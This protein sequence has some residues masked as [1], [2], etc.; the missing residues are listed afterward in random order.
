[1]DAKEYLKYNKKN[2]KRYYIY[3]KNG[4]TGYLK[5]NPDFVSSIEVL[6]DKKHHFFAGYYDLCNISPDGNKCFLLCV[7]KSANPRRDRANII[8]YFFKSKKY[9]NISSTR[10]WC[11]QQGSRIR[12]IDNDNLLYNDYAFGKYI[13]FKVNIVTKEKKFYANSALYD[14]S[15]KSN[16][17]ITLNFNR[18]QCLRPGYGYQ[19]EKYVL[20]E[21]APQDDG[22]FIVNLLSGEKKL[23][24]SLR[25]LSNNVKS[26]DVYHY[27]NHISISPNG[28]KFI[29]FH[30]WTKDNLSMWE[31]ELIVSD[32]DN[33]CNLRSLSGYIFSHYCWINDD[34][35]LLTE[36]SN[37]KARYCIV[38]LNK[39]TIEFINSNE[40]M[41]DGHP[42]LFKKP[43][44]FV[45]DT[46]PLENNLQRVFM[47]DLNKENYFNILTC[48]GDPRYYIDKR[49]D[50]HPR[51]ELK[52]SLISVDSTFSEGLRK[53]ILIKL[54]KSISF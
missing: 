24:I 46:Y 31:M 23:L 42:T 5:F 7:K 13:T 37:D 6:G 21:F 20:R 44:I 51:V 26:K 1:M 43:N 53:V 25:E 18:L 35:L 54:K 40:L 47:Y 48:F 41:Y 50:L 33:K 8:V 39:F 15:F 14:I 16:I 11:W 34:K 32:L 38:E 28:N 22:I 52:H 36:I 4:Y 9:I 45:S 27:I 10:A 2:A 30:L 17:G 12:W 3:K 29:F 19:N 49:C